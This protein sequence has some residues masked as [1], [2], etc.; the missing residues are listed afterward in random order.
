MGLG[1]ESA[2]VLRKTALQ[3]FTRENGGA[4][5]RRVAREILAADYQTITNVAIILLKLRVTF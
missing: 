4:K 2:R 5:G 3:I 1:A